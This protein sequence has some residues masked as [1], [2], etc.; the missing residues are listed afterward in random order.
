MVHLHWPVCGADR[1]VGPTAVLGVLYRRACFVPGGAR[2]PRCIVLADPKR[3]AASTA[4]ENA[5][6]QVVR[7]HFEPRRQFRSKIKH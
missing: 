5:V 4:A 6:A 7:I 1:R 3:D 2:L